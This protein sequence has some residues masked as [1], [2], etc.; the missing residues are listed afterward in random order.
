MNKYI[1]ILSAIVAI[2]V[3]I[4]GINYVKAGTVINGQVETVQNTLPYSIPDPI[5]SDPT[6]RAAGVLDFD[7]T[8]NI[9]S[10]AVIA[11]ITTPT[12]QS[13][14]VQRFIDPSTNVACYYTEQANS[15]VGTS[16]V[17]VS[18]SSI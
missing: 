8:S 11:K 10:A 18:Q 3:G 5:M 12:G 14:N 16:C 1:I 17:L 6:D 4:I 9:P 2:F 13:I 7:E 15:V